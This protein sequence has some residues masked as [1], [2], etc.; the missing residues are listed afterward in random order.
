MAFWSNGDFSGEHMIN[1]ILKILSRGCLKYHLFDLIQ[2]KTEN[3]IKRF[4][5]G[6]KGANKSITAFKK[7]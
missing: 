5:T 3:I 6:Y 7:A 1:S 2:I 4:L